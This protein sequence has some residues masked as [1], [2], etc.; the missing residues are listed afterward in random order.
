MEDCSVRQA[1][2]VP[3]EDQ[4][5]EDCSSKVVAIY[6]LRCLQ[7]EAG[8]RKQFHNTYETLERLPCQNLRTTL[9]PEMGAFWAHFSP[10]L[11]L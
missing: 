10:C 3:G 4:G 5:L 8:E 6:L 11:P 2:G 7:G 1:T 9:H